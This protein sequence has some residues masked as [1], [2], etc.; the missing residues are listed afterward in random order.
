MAKSCNAVQNTG[1]A[2]E[3]RQAYVNGGLEKLVTIESKATPYNKLSIY[4]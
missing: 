3:I 1:S 4:M 2:V